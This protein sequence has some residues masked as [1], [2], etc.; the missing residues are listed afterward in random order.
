[1]V[2][3]ARKRTR[4]ATL[5][6]VLVTLPNDLQIDED[7]NGYIMV[8]ELHGLAASLGLPIASEEQDAALEEVSYDQIPTCPCIL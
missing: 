1:M 4:C 7:G 8:G 5:P 3:P 2:V 6:A